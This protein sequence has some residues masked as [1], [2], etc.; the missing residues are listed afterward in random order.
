MRNI[1]PLGGNRNDTKMTQALEAL[2]I[3]RQCEKSELKKVILL[4][5][6]NDRFGGFQGDVYW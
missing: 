1:W 4:L 5:K 2:N 3:V 6:F